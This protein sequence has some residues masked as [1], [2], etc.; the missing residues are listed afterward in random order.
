MKVV[1][2]IFFG[3]NCDCDFVVVLMKVG[4][5]VMC[6]WYKDQDLL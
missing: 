2:I 1:V 5:D 3:L 6:V 4:V